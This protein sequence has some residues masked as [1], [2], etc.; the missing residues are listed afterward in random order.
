M[1]SWLMVCIPA[2]MMIMPKPT[3]F[4]TTEMMTAR[5]PVSALLNQT[6]GASMTPRSTSSLLKSPTCWSK[7]QTQSRL[8]L[9]SPITTGRNTTPRVTCTT[10][11]LTV[12]RSASR[13]PRPIRTGV[14]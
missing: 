6:I 14:M 11:R 10:G 8:E 1:T 9:A 3:T 12:I 13:N 7:S 5:R 2:S 4:H